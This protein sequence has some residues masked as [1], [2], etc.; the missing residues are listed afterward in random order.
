L[1][2]KLV[3]CLEGEVR[4]YLEVLAESLGLRAP[5]DLEFL[6][7]YASREQ[8]KARELPRRLKRSPL[9]ERVRGGY[10]LT[11][12]GR[13]V[14]ELLELKGDVLRAPYGDLDVR[15]GCAKSL[16]AASLLATMLTLDPRELRSVRDEGALRALAL[17]AMQALGLGASIYAI[18][19]PLSGDEAHSVVAGIARL[20]DISPIAVEECKSL[21]WKAITRSTAEEE[22]ELVR[23]LERAIAEVNRGILVS[24]TEALGSIVDYACVTA[25]ERGERVECRELEEATENLLRIIERYLRGERGS[26]NQEAGGPAGI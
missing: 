23:L 10:R 20:L 22:V 21:L 18:A 7:S 16:L 3:L 2:V 24:V 25:R 4:G 12:L 13:L 11:V 14:L 5:R 9:V 15:S 19:P 26:E 8:L 17:K 6:R 1:R